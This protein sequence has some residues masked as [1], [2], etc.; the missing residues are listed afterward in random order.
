MIL[1]LA[2]EHACAAQHGP[3]ECCKEGQTLSCWRTAQC[4]RLFAAASLLLLLNFPTPAPLPE[5]HILCIPMVLGVQK[6]ADFTLLED[7]VVLVEFAERQ[8]L[9]QSRPGMGLRLVTFYRRSDAGD[10]GHK[11]LQASGG[12][13]PGWGCC[14][15][16]CVFVAIMQLCCLH[17]ITGM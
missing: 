17:I 11:A 13:P 10:A 9:L 16:T 8:P 2:G 3:D 12:Q 6:R 4:W 7:S 5:R 15:P 14:L 1:A